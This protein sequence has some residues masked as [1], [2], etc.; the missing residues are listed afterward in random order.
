MKK[1]K[2]MKEAHCQGM[3][4][5]Y[6]NGRPFVVFPNANFGIQINSD[7]KVWICVDGVA[8]IRFKPK[9]KPKFNK[10]EKNDQ[11]IELA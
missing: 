10:G 4:E 2:K 5:I 3:L 7:G 1:F 9:S 8:L 11:R 6:Q